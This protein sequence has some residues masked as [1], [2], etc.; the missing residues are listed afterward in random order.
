M[1]HKYDT[2][3]IVTL[4]SKILEKS[5]SIE[6][7][8]VAT[9]WNNP[10]LYFEHSSDVDSQMFKSE[11]WKMYFEIGEAMCKKGFKHIDELAVMTYLENKDE[12]RDKYVN[13]G[14][15]NKIE[16]A[17]AMVNESNVQAHIDELKKYSAIFDYVSK[18][19]LTEKSIDKLANLDSV[20]EIYNFLTIK[21][22]DVFRSASTTGSRSGKI[23]DD[24]DSLI[25]TAD[26]GINKGMP[27]G[28]PILSEEVGGLMDGQII[29]VGG[30]SGTGK[31]TFTQ[32]LHLSA[33]WEREESTVCILNEQPKEKWQ[34]QFLT[35]IINNKIIPSDSHERFSSKRWRDG[36]FT[37]KEKEWL[38][39][40][41][42]MLEEKIREN[43]IIIEELETYSQKNAEKI[44]KRYA[45][46][47][48]KYFVLDT[49]K[50]DADHKGD[51]FWFGM[52]ESMR[53]FDD[54]VKPTNLNV[55][56]WVTL[57][58]EKGAVLKRYLTGN[59]IGM[60]KNVVD[61][62]S[63]ALLMRRVRNDEY[64][65]GKNELKVIKPFSKDCRTSGVEVELD[66]N[67]QYVIIFIEK[68]RNGESQT[69]QIVAQQDLGCLK[70]REI[71]VTDIPFDC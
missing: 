69:Y 51:L 46:L 37:E 31:T 52:Q 61:V 28:S 12:I 24:L 14:G 7:N 10:D 70:Y 22:N 65:G 56:L 23:T 66:P 36:H 4:R 30:L 13:M 62:A 1:E 38:Y 3:Y 34:Q 55:N 41:K 60:A 45:H 32:E 26:K 68:N 64:K 50:V 67:K 35:W 5:I 49:F 2:G 43:L 42:S 16:L 11:L 27:F 53:K 39:K 63:V 71:G 21:M 20:E 40:A 58:L 6:S 19:S 17:L 54:L 47:G 29:L 18:L 25:E 9:F 48:V 15:Y 33:M 57:Q 8:V 44:I 59:N